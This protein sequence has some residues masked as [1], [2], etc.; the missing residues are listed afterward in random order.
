MSSLSN[1]DLKRK[2]LYAYGR[3]V[4]P[5]GE[6]D[7]RWEANKIARHS[8]EKSKKEDPYTMHHLGDDFINTEDYPDYPQQFVLCIIPV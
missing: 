8:V 2:E 5:N 3:R 7:D 1:A 4:L 6:R